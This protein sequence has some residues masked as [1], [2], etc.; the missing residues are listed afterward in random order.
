[1]AKEK[2]FIYGK[3]GWPHTQKARSA[4][5]DNAKYFDVEA[6]SKK[7]DDMLKYSGGVREVPVIVE[8]SKVTIGYGGTWGVWVTGSLP[9]RPPGQKEVKARKF[10]FRISNCEFRI[11]N[12][13]FKTSRNPHCLPAAGMDFVALMGSFFLTRNSPLRPIL[14]GCHSDLF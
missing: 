4:Y 11:E 10:W 1:M 12:Q 14:S 9:E 3:A 13:F 2:V 6:D 8:G 5:G 7:L